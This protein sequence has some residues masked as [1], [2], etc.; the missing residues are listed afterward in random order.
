MQWR[1]LVHTIV[2]LFLI[3]AL[4]ARPVA[5]P[6]AHSGS[7]SSALPR[8]SRAL[9]TTVSR[10]AVTVRQ[11]LRATQAGTLL[12]TSEAVD[13]APTV[14]NT[15]PTSTPS[16]PTPPTS[17]STPAHSA[18]RDPVPILMYHYIRPRPG[19]DDPLGQRLSVDPATFQAQMDWLAQHGFT[20]ITL[21]EL[22]ALRAGLIPAPP[23]PIVL[24]FDDGYRDFY[25]NAF[26]ILR[27]HGFHAT[28]FV[29]TGFVGQERYLTW[30]MIRE[31]DR[32]GLVEIG[33]HTV[34]HPD[35][36]TLA[37]P[38]SEIRGCKDALEHVLGHPVTAFAYP[39]GKFDARVE[40]AVRAAGFRQAVTTQ[41]RWATSGDD[42]LALPRLRVTGDLTLA[43]FA[44][45]LT[46]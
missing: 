40:T 36:T 10:R 20:P 23:H 25:Q 41:P 9:V 43:Q 42:P 28:V 45:L 14:T 19:S 37:N 30:D 34:H 39:A 6:F 11:R 5:T 13:R 8:R 15:I 7:S 38:E 3:G 22:A 1:V 33:A 35:L 12:P 32:S 2:F 26:P 4:L 16:E 44:A 18:F 27:A 24:T 21:S 46:G 17:T 29:V 31:L